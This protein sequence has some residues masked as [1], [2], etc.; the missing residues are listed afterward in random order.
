MKKTLLALAAI[1]SV[2]A[3]AG[4]TLDKIK[5]SGKVVLGVRASSAPFSSVQST[6]GYDGYSVAV[7]KDI[8]KGLSADLKKPLEIEYKE[9]DTSTRY[10]LID[11]GVIDLECAG[12]SYNPDK[13]AV[14]NY[15][16]HFTDS[17]L[18]ASKAGT[19][20]KDL[21][22]L[23][24]AR[25]GMVA[26]FSGEKNIRQ[27]FTDKGVEITDSNLQKAQNYD[28]LFLL[29]KQN[30]IDAIITNKAILVGEIAKQRDSKNYVVLENTKIKENDKLGIVSPAKDQE[31]TNKVKDQVKTLYKNGTLEK[32]SKQY[33]GDSLSTESKRDIAENK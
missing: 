1:L 14:A 25:V 26:S 15:S 11:S 18:A 28:A 13:L 5:D 17:I 4:T 8:V 30:R 21:N 19:S 16:I 24:K 20:I 32:Y 27:F 22:D 6:G 3:Y 23:S 33:F 10:T 12:S 7:C 2:N 9:V 29:L 31:F